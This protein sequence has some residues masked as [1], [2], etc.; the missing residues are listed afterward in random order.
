MLY[1]VKSVL[2]AFKSNL[3]QY[4]LSPRILLRNEVARHGPKIYKGLIP[5]LWLL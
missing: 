4:G 2:V 3:S 5:L 1:L